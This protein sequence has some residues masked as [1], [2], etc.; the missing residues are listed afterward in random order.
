MERFDLICCHCLSGQV[1]IKGTATQYGAR[2][3][4]VIHCKSCG[5]VEEIPEEEVSVSMA[6]FLLLKSR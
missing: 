1:E 2:I 6:D 4:C 5:D 3:R